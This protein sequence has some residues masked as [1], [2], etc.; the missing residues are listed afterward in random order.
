M[1]TNRILCR[2]ALGMLMVA[3]SVRLAQATEDGDDAA[4]TGGEPQCGNGGTMTPVLDNSRLARLL[5]DASLSR[6]VTEVT[7]MA[8]SG[9]DES[10]LLAQVRNSD[11]PYNLRSED[12]AHLREHNVSD[13]VI[14]AMIERGGELR[15]RVPPTPPP[16][17]TVP[18]VQAQA[19]STVTYVPAVKPCTVRPASTL[20][21]IGRSN[22][23]S[24][25]SY[26]NYYY[27]PRRYFSSTPYNS[28]YASF[29]NYALDSCRPIYR[30]GS[31]HRVWR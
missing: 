18:V 31:G 8:E 19:S 28:V 2:A 26:R 25:L 10:V 9:T 15:A 1:K 30:R 29:G 22:L 12:I 27:S 6:G 11:T 3:V 20:I 7:R 5:K 17:P 24:G 13:S 21:I 16:V 23:R 14:T 4:P